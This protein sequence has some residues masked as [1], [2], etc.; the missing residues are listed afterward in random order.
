VWAAACPG[1]LQIFSP[2]GASVSSSL[3]TLKAF[4]EVWRHVGPQRGWSPRMAKL[5]V[6]LSAIAKLL[7]VS[8]P[9]C[10]LEHFTEPL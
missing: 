7:R 10:G 8:N 1:C 6:E 9:L 5:G 4:R 3:K 2:P